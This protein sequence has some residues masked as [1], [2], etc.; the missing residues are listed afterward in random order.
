MLGL[1][2]DRLDKITKVEKPF[3][4]TTNR[5]PIGKRRHNTKYFLVREEDGKRVFDI[6][7][8]TSWHSVSI[9][10]EEYEAERKLKNNRVHKYTPSDLTQKPEFI[11]YDHPPHILGTVYPEGYFQFKVGARIH[12][13]DRKFLS[14]LSNGWFTCDS[15]RG[16]LVYRA[17]A[18][19][20]AS[21][22]MPIYE[23]M[24]VYTD[25]MQP[26]DQYVVIGRK[27]DRKA[28]RELVKPYENFYR[29]SEVMCKALDKESFLKIAE[30]VYANVKPQE[31]NKYV[32]AQDFLR[33]AEALREEAPLD[34]MILYCFGMQVGNI[35]NAM[36]NPGW[37]N[38]TPSSVHSNL[39]RTINTGLYKLHPEVFKPVEYQ[40]GEAYPQSPWGYEVMV[41]GESKSQYD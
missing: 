4:G 38:I 16:G 18:Y 14:D 15:R 25:T 36:R 41:N 3:R 6:V 8:G 32:S 31:G 23:G 7:F 34:A 5:F 26:L 19:G 1:N 24:R 12:Q 11:R 9:T 39:M 29:V 20:S 17:F 37:H 21:I 28:S 40:M 2:Y 35:P 33:D 22:P 27:V 10:E 30:E 13:G